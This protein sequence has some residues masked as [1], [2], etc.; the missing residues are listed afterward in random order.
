MNEEDYFYIECF[1]QS[2]DDN[3]R[4]IWDSEFEAF[5]LDFRIERFPKNNFP[6]RKNKI[7]N[8][9]DKIRNYII[10]IVWAIKGRPN[11]FTVNT[12]I[13]RKEAKKLI[14]YINKKI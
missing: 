1:C 12:I 6:E 8:T 14:D 13:N 4:I 3:M 5:I 7:F 2:Y 11:W 9:F 10:N